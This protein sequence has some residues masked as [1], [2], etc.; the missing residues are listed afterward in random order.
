MT[1]SH[2]TLGKGCSSNNTLVK[3]SHE[4]ARSG[5]CTLGDFNRTLVCAELSK[6]DPDAEAD[7]V[8]YAIWYMED[9]GFVVAFAGTRNMRDWLSNL[10][11]LGKSVNFEDAHSEL[12]LH[13]GMN[14]RALSVLDRIQG[15][16]QKERQSEGLDDKRLLFTGHSLGGGT[17][18]CALVHLS[19]DTNNTQRLELQGV[20]TF[21][22]PLVLHKTDLTEDM[23]RSMG[24]MH[25]VVNDMDIVPRLLGK[26]L[27]RSHRVLLYL[28]TGELSKI[29]KAFHPFGR[30]SHIQRGKA[31]KVV[32]SAES[33]ALLE[34]SLGKL[35]RRTLRTGL[36]I[37]RGLGDLVSNH[38]MKS[39]QEILAETLGRLIKER[40]CKKSQRGYKPQQGRWL[41]FRTS[42]DGMQKAELPLSEDAQNNRA[43][44]GADVDVE[45]QPSCSSGHEDAAEACS[46][47]FASHSAAGNV[48][49][50]FGPVDMPS[51]E[52]MRATESL[53]QD[54]AMT[55][56]MPSNITPEVLPA[57]SCRAGFNM[58]P[59]Q[60]EQMMPEAC[61]VP[62]VF[63]G[64]LVLAYAAI[65]LQRLGILPYF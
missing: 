22:A 29:A 30:F 5:P 20:V 16:I 61:K 1:T 11:F 51:A 53:R 15:A 52:E 9:L 48:I 64:I 17:A 56:D 12:Y 26:A 59:Q 50:R 60:A 18:V 8:Q 3:P 42:V 33:P 6:Q 58:P 27:K 2:H 28:G 40:A 34:Y 14:Q 41:L 45:W 57:I 25:H 13:S 10:D 21:G 44:L 43:P 32:D 47:T 46:T 4:A 24:D 19:F 35:V 23:K 54:P 39:Y 31:L 36:L 49:D 63:I 65:F 37:P 7:K 62:M 55:S 38:S